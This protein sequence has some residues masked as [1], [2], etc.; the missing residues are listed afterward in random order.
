MFSVTW[1]RTYNEKDGSR[2]TKDSQGKPNIR[3]RVGVTKDFARND[4]AVGGTEDGA[5]GD[6]HGWT[7]QKSC[8]P[9]PRAKGAL[10][11]TVTQESICRSTT[12]GL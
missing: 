8:G 11:R 3:A 6:R 9:C 7:W 4:T 12:R 10:R 1:E 2:L 5:V